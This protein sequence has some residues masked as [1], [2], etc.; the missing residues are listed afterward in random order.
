MTNKA[1][2]TP[3]IMIIAT[4][5]RAIFTFWR[6]FAFNC[7]ELIVVFFIKSQINALLDEGIIGWGMNI[8]IKSII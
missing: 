1:V 8:V 4:M 5:G 7:G 6:Y 2:I 3:I